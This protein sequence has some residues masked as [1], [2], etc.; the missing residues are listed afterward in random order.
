MIPILICCIYGCLAA[1]VATALFQWPFV[2][3]EGSINALWAI[4]FLALLHRGDR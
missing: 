1:L 2:P 3:L 4:L